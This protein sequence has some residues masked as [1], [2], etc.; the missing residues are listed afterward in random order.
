MFMLIVSVHPYC[1]QKSHAT[2]SI[3]CAPSNKMNH[4]RAD[5]Y[6]YSLAWIKWSWMVTKAISLLMDH[7]LYW[8]SM[9]SE[10][11]KKIYLIRSLIWL[12]IWFILKTLETMLIDTWHD[13][14]KIRLVFHVLYHCN[15]VHEPPI[16]FFISETSNY[17]L[18]TV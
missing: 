1:A 14:F 2:S 15:T 8:F 11:L 13:F 4:D 9:F 16:S 10:K 18:C 5:C 3:K 6:C 7:F 17:H 12:I